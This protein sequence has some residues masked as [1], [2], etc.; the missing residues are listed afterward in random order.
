[1]M[2][3]IKNKKTK[4]D[5]DKLSEHLQN[6]ETVVRQESNVTLE[7]TIQSETKDDNEKTF[8]H[9]FSENNAVDYIAFVEKE[10]AR[11]KNLK[12]KKEYQIQLK[13]NKRLQALFRNDEISV[14]IKRKRNVVRASDNFFDEIF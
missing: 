10:R 8:S 5:N 2:S 1:M 14:S 9:E 13:K 11:N 7:K 6:A 12:V 4:N 3:S